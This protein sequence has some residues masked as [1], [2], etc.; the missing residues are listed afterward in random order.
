MRLRLNS[1][2]LMDLAVYRALATECRRDIALLSPS[3]MS[4]IGEVMRC[5][6]QDLEVAARA[7][8]VVRRSPQYTAR[9]ALTLDS[10]LHGR[11]IRTVI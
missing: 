3:L 9:H 2:V 7:A 5:L 6:S 1:L 10:S 4:S 11:R 8:S